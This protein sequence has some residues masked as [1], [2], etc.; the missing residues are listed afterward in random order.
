MS[1][2]PATAGGSETLKTQPPKPKP[3]SFLAK[4]PPAVARLVTAAVLLPILVVSIIFPQLSLLFVL[5]T[6]AALVVALFEFWLLARKQQIRADA[7]AGLLS[8]AALLTVFFFTE[9]GK[10]PDLLMIQLTL[11]LLTIGSLVAAMLRGTP[12]DRM[13]TSAGV[14]VLS[15]MY[16]VLLGG[17]MVALRVGF[18]PELSKHLLAFFFLV[19]M[20]ADAAAYYGGRAFGKHKLA[21]AISPGKTW[22]G[23][24]AGMLAS[25]LIAAAAHY[26]F[27]LELPTKFALPLAALMNVVSVI[28]DLTESALKRSAGAKDTARILPGHGGVLDRLDSLLFNAPVI[29][30]FARLYFN[31]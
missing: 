20:G 22:E 16:I 17:H 11:I 29:Y 24:V 19:I 3:K 18:A 23:A 9:P 12:F 15:V 10:L 5:L 25:L 28:G 21:P 4:L 26:W 27:F 14:T 31:S 7:A 8:A 30:Y 6:A 2:P 13:I 1:Q